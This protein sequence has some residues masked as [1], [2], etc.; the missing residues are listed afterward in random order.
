[1]KPVVVAIILILFTSGASAQLQ[2]MDAPTREQ[3]MFWR[4]ARRPSVDSF[5]LTI[6]FPNKLTPYR[7]VYPDGKEAG[8]F[9]DWDY[10]NVHFGR[11]FEQRKRFV[12]RH[13]NDSVLIYERYHSNQIELF[14]QTPSE[15]DAKRLLYRFDRTGRLFYKR[16]GMQF[17]NNAMEYR[18]DTAGRL[19]ERLEIRFPGGGWGDMQ[20][21]GKV[22]EIPRMSRRWSWLYD[23]KGNLVRDDEYNRDSI[24]D[25]SHHY[26][27][28][29]TGR[30]RYMDSYRRDTIF[31]GRTFY[32]YGAG[33]SVEQERTFAERDTMGLVPTGVYRYIYSKDVSFK[34]KEMQIFANAQESKITDV[35]P[36]NF[37]H[38]TVFFDSEG[39]KIGEVYRVN[40]Y[41]E[42]R[43]NAEGQ[44][45]A[46]RLI[47]NRYPGFSTWEA[48]HHTGESYFRNNEQYFYNA[49]GSLRSIEWYNEDIK[50]VDEY[51]YDSEG[52][53][54]THIRYSPDGKER[55]VLRITYR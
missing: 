28:D 44:L 27:Y 8:Y 52:K 15:P 2:G 55:R 11:E 54:M 23:E 33:D 53:P 25:Y 43:R 4:A 40:K 46:F 32:L 39:K 38:D 6:E 9:I 1:M 21:L 30:V 18:Y 35:K 47:E 41:S 17:D 12:V 36:Y 16:C 48:F 50:H 5:T 49:D 51:T 45:T 26:L 7:H 20:V 42:I 19:T 13:T 10:H 29:E 22:V 24:S 37:T 34:S 31:S 3:E 14:K